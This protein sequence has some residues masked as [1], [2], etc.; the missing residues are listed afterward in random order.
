[1]ERYALHLP[2]AAG[3][4][5]AA[6]RAW[7]LGAALWIPG[8]AL[9]WR[10]FGH[11]A[12]AWWLG[13]AGAALA[14]GAAKEAGACEPARCLLIV[15]AFGFVP[16][17]HAVPDTDAAAWAPFLLYWMAVIL[18][19]LDGRLGPLRHPGQ[20]AAPKS[21]L[22]PAGMLLA[23]VMGKAGPWYAAVGL[24]GPIQ[25]AMLARRRERGLPTVFTPPGAVRRFFYGCLIGTTGGMLL[26]AA[27]RLVVE[28]IAFGMVLPF[29]AGFVADWR[30][31][32]R[33]S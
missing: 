10:L 28:P 1:M 14:F 25:A 30:R 3:R 32:P 19:G 22:L 24:L 16:A 8:Y 5:L 21:V 9:A 26:P 7:G 6:W 4:T 11:A 15:L 33:R 17:A 20:G 18:D 29:V 23:V 12:A 27:E 31:G 13:G 2:G